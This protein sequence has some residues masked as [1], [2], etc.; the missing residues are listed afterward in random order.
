MAL[1]LYHVL[2]LLE[3]SEYIVTYSFSQPNL[4]IRYD[5]KTFYKEEE[6]REG[7]VP[8]R[9]VEVIQVFIFNASG[10]VY[11]QKRSREKNHN[12]RLLDKTVGGHVQHGDSVMYTVMVET[13]QELRVPSIVLHND[14]DFD[15]SLDLLKSYIGVTCLL[16]HIDTKVAT[17]SK[18]IKKRSVSIGTKYHLYFGVYDGPIK[19]VD[20][21]AVGVLV[22]SLEDLLEEMAENPE[23]FTADMHYFT[24]EYKKE[25]FKF[26][27]LVVQRV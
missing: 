26:R 17:L 6:E 25:L 16:K 20:K 11:I 23:E 27:D 5:R 21:E 10:E 18:L 2:T 9:A 22:Y 1:L 8:L 4:P 12:P 14:E 7:E 19:T 3:M 15:R 13:V 24:K